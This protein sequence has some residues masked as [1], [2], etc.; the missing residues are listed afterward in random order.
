MTK[1]LK[2]K[3]RNND[4]EKK[5]VNCTKKFQDK[6]LKILSSSTNSRT[7]KNSRT[8]PGFSGFSGRVDTLRSTEIKSKLTNL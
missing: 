8:F 2:A 4:C 7:E 3:Y 5:L 6:T 1:L